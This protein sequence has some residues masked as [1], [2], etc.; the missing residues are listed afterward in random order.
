MNKWEAAF[1]KISR[2]HLFEV[3]DELDIAPPFAFSFRNSNSYIPELIESELDDSRPPFQK[4]IEL[5]GRDVALATD[6]LVCV[7]KFLHVLQSARSNALRG[8][9]TWSI[10]DSYHASLLGA[11][12]ICALMGVVPYTVRKRTVLI[13]FRPEFGSPQ[14]R[15]RFRKT[16]G[17]PNNPI[18]IFVPQPAHLEQKHIWALMHRQMAFARMTRQRPE[19]DTIMSAIDGSP[20]EFRNL[21]MYDSLGWLRKQD[22]STLRQTI[23]T[24][25][26]IDNA[27]AP[28][29]AAIQMGDA[30]YS[31][32]QDSVFRLRGKIGLTA[33]SL[34]GAIAL[35][36]STCVLSA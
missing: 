25:T 4:I 11:R 17:H 32:I 6:A 2:R 22:C 35:A 31:L 33:N 21:V 34:P 10:V 1:S 23:M 15:T 12:A 24:A 14:D 5:P 13:D 20:A 30:I 3:I 16:H 19:F 7:V 9:I 29:I 28:N 27:I 36:P 26:Q 8:A 18:A